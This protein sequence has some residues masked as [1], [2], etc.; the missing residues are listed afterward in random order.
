MSDRKT[1]FILIRTAICSLL[2][3]S[4]KNLID[5]EVIVGEVANEPTLYFVNI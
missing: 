3:P 1:S 5:L 4:T 2:Q